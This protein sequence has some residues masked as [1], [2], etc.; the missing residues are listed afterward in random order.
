[1]SET[2]ETDTPTVIPN[3]SVSSPMALNMNGVTYQ[4]RTVTF[5]TPKRTV[6]VRDLDEADSWDLSEIAG[7]QNADNPIW[8]ARALAATAMVAIDSV[9]VVNPTASALPASVIRQ[10]LRLL[11]TLGVIAV[12]RA[13]NDDGE[14]VPAPNPLAVAGNL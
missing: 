6:E 8:M 12:I 1:M 5:G 2:T 10:R 13:I 9:P 14:A 3:Y 4:V 11:G 7:K